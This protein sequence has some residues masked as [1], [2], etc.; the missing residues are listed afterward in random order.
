MTISGARG[1]CAESLVSCL[2]CLGLPN[3]LTRSVLK[4]MS[5]MSLR[6]SFDIWMARN[7]SSWNFEPKSPFFTDLNKNLSSSPT[8][9]KQLPKP[10]AKPHNNYNTPK[11]SSKKNHVVSPPIKSSPHSR[12]FHCGLFN[13]GNTCYVNVILQ[14]LKPLTGIWTNTSNFTHN[15]ASPLVSSFHKVMAQLDSCKSCVD[16]SSFLSSLENSIRKSGSH[17]FNIHHQQDVV[18]VLDHIL[19]ELVVDSDTIM[20]KHSIETSC[21]SCY[22]SF[23]REDVCTM[24]QMPIENNIQNSLH[25]FLRSELLD[26]DN[27]YFCA[28]CA[29]KQPAETQVCLRN[30]GTYLIIQ[31]KRFSFSDGVVTK[32]SFPV[33]CS[34]YLNVPVR[35]DDEVT[36]IRKFA[37]VSGICHSGKLNSG[38]YTAFVRDSVC[39]VWLNL[40]D[41]AVNET[42]LKS[43]HGAQPYV[44][45]YKAC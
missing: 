1:F 12:H 24:L 7:S 38:H 20:V 14:A 13:K 43:L 26:G 36:C 17:T 11:D 6:C 22:N 18:E 35:I 23:S 21:N 9:S 8:S 4:D 3:K 28:I 45:F 42:Q 19:G 2:R 27:A 15:L 32:N 10:Y 16:P 25:Y 41:R 40:N 44:L 37:L 5:N 31:L 29:S 34:P 33:V 30:I 39:G